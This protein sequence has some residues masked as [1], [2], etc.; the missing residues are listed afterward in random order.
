VLWQDYILYTNL[1]FIELRL[2]VEWHEKQKM[3][4]LAFPVNVEKPTL[5]CEIPYGFI[6]RAINGEEEP[7]QRWVDLTGITSANGKELKYGVTIASDSVYSYSALGSEIRLTLLRSPIYAHHDPRKPVSGVDYKYID[8]GIHHFKL[9]ILP[10]AG[11]WRRANVILYAELVNSQIPYIIESTHEGK[12][13]REFSF[14]KTNKKNV[15]VNV[16]KLAEDS[17][18]IV[19]RLYEVHGVRTEVEINLPW[20]KRTLRT[21]INPY[22]IKSLLVSLDPDKPVR[23]CNLIES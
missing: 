18:D 12:L 23:E 7:M 15:I 17:D 10:H 20:I 19:L 2:R 11:S 5:T 13:P 1:D 21:T 14:I 6:E 22:E 3:L 4:K 8:Q 9:L 16:V